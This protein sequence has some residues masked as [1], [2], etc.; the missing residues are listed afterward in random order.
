[1]GVGGWAGGGGG[2][3]GGRRGRLYTYRYNVITRMTPE[4]RSAATRAILKDKSKVRG[5]F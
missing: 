3:G 2:Y 5:D 4:L 1:M